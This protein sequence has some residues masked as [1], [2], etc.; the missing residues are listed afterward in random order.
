M[1]TGLKVTL[2]I[3]GGLFVISLIAGFYA[4]AIID[5]NAEITDSDRAMLFTPEE[6]QDYFEDYTPLDEEIVLK[7][8]VYFPGIWDIELNYDPEADDQPFL[9]YKIS[10]SMSI[11]QARYN[12]LLEVK[13]IELGIKLA[14]DNTVFED[15][16][17]D[18][19]SYPNARLKLF[20]VDGEPYGN[21]F[22]TTIG[23]HSIILFLTSFYFDDGEVFAEMI[24]PTLEAVSSN[25]KK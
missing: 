6:L 7:K 19:S 14:A 22:Y 4:Y 5:L 20:T 16:E 12:A 3:G 25:N 8:M 24:N 21:L 11:A 15:L 18:Q 1:R 13:A 23:R 9:S 2:I 10:T 17:F